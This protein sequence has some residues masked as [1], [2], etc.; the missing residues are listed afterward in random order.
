V[1]WRPERPEG[2]DEP[3]P[4]GG[5]LDRVVRR[6]GA[7][8]VSALDHVFTHW[9]EVVGE[10]VAAHAQPL[11]LRNGTLV[12][13]VDNPA[14]VTQLRLLGDELLERLQAAAGAG[15]VR[16]LEVRVRA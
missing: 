3:R 13:G 15:A 2:G 9:D 14:W 11:S 1:S 4:I 8:S 5:A 6:F 16:T 12:I 10:G 7:P